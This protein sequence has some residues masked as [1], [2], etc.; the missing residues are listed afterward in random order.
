VPPVSFQLRS[1]H[2]RLRLECFG[3]ELW[4]QSI[5]ARAKPTRP[6]TEPHAT[7]PCRDPG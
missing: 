7:G 2:W 3:P 6:P 4:G 1:V 5:A